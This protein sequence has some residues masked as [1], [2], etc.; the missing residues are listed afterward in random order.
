VA[1]SPDGRHIVTGSEDQT[2]KVWDAA[3]GRELLTLQ[4]HRNSIRAVAYSP[5]GQRIATGS[6]DHTAILW[7]PASGT[8]RF[9]LEG[10]SDQIS[11]LAFSPDGQRIITGSADQTA[12]LWEAASGREL[13]T[14]KGHTARILSVAYSRDGQRI[15]TGSSDHTAK[16]WQ[17]ARAEQIESWQVEEQAAARVLAA[18]Q[19]QQSAEQARQ[20]LALADDAGAIKQWR[21]LAPIPLSAGQSGAQALDTEQIEGE[22]WLQPAAVE[23]R[24]IGG[25]EL[26]WT[27]VVL[28]DHVI[29]LNAFVGRET[30]RS[31]AYAVCFLRSETEQRTLRILIS[32]DDKA[33]LYLN[34]QQVYKAPFHHPSNEDEDTVPNI[35]LKAGLNLLVF[36]LVN[37]FGLWHGSVRFTDAQGN[38]VRGIQV[39]LEANAKAR[40]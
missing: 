38:P 2:A 26:K 3:N 21:I 16:V 37:E 15:V 27:D 30:L 20:R 11:A 13:L 25:H 35:T 17:A 1:Y 34:G 7:D 18:L 12:K 32:S 39:T 9:T 28:E 10:H 5:D 4:G 22:S 31:V 8:K 24:A 36:K 40:P 19:R 6:T 23:M 33:A 29:D 14:F